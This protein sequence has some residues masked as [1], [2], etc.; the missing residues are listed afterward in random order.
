MKR[1]SDADTAVYLQMALTTATWL[2]IGGTPKVASAR[3][4]VN[5]QRRPRFT[6]LRI[7]GY[8]GGDVN[9]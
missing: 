6:L 2:R 4:L 9:N 8:A 3:C 7:R 1:W 5:F